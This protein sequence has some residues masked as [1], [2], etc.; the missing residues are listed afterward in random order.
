VP[1]KNYYAGEGINDISILDEIWPEEK[2]ALLVWFDN[3]TWRDYLFSPEEILE[4]VEVNEIVYLSDGTI[5]FIN[6]N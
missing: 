3:I 1:N 4:I 2:T 5:Y 6:N